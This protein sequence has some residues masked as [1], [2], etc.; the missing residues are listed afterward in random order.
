MHF[1]LASSTVWSTTFLCV[2]W[3][4]FFFTSFFSLFFL[5]PFSLFF[6]LKHP[7]TSTIA[8]WLHAP[9]PIVPSV[10]LLLPSATPVYTVTSPFPPNHPTLYNVPNMV[11]LHNIEKKPKKN[12]TKLWHFIW[13]PWLCHHLSTHYILSSTSPVPPLVLFS[14]PSVLSS[15]S[16]S[17][18][19]LLPPWY[20]GLPVD[21]AACGLRT[22]PDSTPLSST[23]LRLFPLFPVPSPPLWPP[24]APLLPLL[25]LKSV[26]PHCLFI[27]F[28]TLSSFHLLY[29]ITTVTWQGGHVFVSFCWLFF[30]HWWLV[31]RLWGYGGWG[32]CLFFWSLYEL[33]LVVVGLCEGNEVRSLYTAA[34][35]HLFSLLA[36]PQTCHRC[37]Q[38]DKLFKAS[39]NYWPNC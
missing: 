35:F 28:G 30:N 14:C 7:F 25:S 12:K 13:F 39:S 29:F 10:H 23:P 26:T 4:C 36:Q 24:P 32:G 19:P 37:H 27:L 3:P 15:S 16:S 6:V 8:N 5:S 1:N 34:A 17:L 20:C 11:P 31:I 9:W 33:F 18:M 38:W 2:Y 21:L 22:C